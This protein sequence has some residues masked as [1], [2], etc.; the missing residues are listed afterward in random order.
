[1][2]KRQIKVATVTTSIILL[3][4]IIVVIG[5]N[6][7]QKAPDSAPVVTP[8]TQTSTG[9]P[10]AVPATQTPPTVTEP[11]T[12]QVVVEPVIPTEYTTFADE[13][14]LFSISYPQDWQVDQATV[15][16]INKKMKA[17]VNDITG[18][19][20]DKAN[21][22]FLAG[23]MAATEYV[24]NVNIVVAPLPPG[25][26][27][28]NQAVEANLQVLKKYMQEFRLVSRSEIT[29]GGRPATIIDAEGIFP[30]KGKTHAL[31]MNMVVDKTLWTVTGGAAYDTF[32]DWEKDLNS[33]VRSLRIIK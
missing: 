1:M 30:G 16:D 2:M 31:Q 3:A 33:V 7:P 27:T 20:T 14:N 10:P 25:V 6:S 22:I 4:G 29:C 11:A 28:A 24:V 23:K 26:S 21:I 32:A 12:P 18:L 15:Q 5:C 9:N 8:S 19:S 13:T 17:L